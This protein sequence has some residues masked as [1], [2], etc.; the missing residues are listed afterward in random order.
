MAQR[1][2]LAVGRVVRLRVLYLQEKFKKAK[3]QN[4]WGTAGV[5]GGGIPAERGEMKWVR[6]TGGGNPPQK[7]TKRNR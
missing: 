4:G 2:D 5:G 6:D 1:T 3:K 7:N